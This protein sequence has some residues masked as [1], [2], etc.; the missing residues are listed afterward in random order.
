MLCTWKNL[1][2]NFSK[3]N[4]PTDKNMKAILGFLD[5]IGGVFKMLLITTL[6]ATSS[7]LNSLMEG[8]S[9]LES[10]WQPEAEK[11]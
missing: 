3:G 11:I 5:F 10:V 7:S 6:A 4:D 1:S 9:Q 2:H 8:G